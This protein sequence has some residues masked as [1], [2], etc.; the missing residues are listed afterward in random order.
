MSQAGN[1]SDRGPIGMAVK[2]AERLVLEAPKS[3]R[4]GVWRFVSILS[5][6]S[7]I[8]TGYV[9]VRHPEVVH[10]LFEDSQVVE[11]SEIFRRRPAVREEV[12]TMLG[13]FVST[14]SP[15]RIALVSW[16]SQVGIQEVWSNRSSHDWPISTNGQLSRNMGESIASIIFDECWTGPIESPSHPLMNGKEWLVCGLSS[17]DD[18]WGFIVAQW[19]GSGVPPRAKEYLHLLSNRAERRMFD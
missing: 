12:M 8:S 4:E 5:L 16:E 2:F 19:D 17:D 9:I 11:I 13:T 7:V 10:N 6:S 15:S 3:F 1:N 18:L 14:F